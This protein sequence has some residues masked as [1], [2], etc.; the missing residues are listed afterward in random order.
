VLEPE[1]HYIAL[2][3]GG[4]NDDEVVA[5]VRDTRYLQ[6]L[7]DR[8]YRDIMTQ[9]ELQK[10]FYVGQLD[11]ILAQAWHEVWGEI[12]SVRVLTEALRR[13]LGSISSRAKR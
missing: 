12:G 8:A 9:P 3:P 2:D 6:A 11:H 7:V 1:R 10:S 13:R 4:G 5:K